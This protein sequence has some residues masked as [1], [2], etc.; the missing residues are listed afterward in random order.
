MELQKR[1]TG[2][3]TNPRHE[4]SV[5][6]DEAADVASIYRT[7]IVILAAIPAAAIVLG[8]LRFG[9][10]PAMSSGIA[11]YVMGVAQPIIVALAVEKLAPRFQ[12]T[13]TTVS[14]LKL[15]AYAA[16]PVW[17]AGAAYLLFFLVPLLLLAAL[18]SIYLFYL[19]LPILLGTP[20]DKAVPF[21]VVTAL[22]VIVTNI[23]LAWL[24]SGLLSHP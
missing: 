15:V 12:S 23:V 2:I 1:L 17:V 20:Q 22:A 21:M 9:M 24:L 13:A 8:R 19:G 3:L 14:A 7:Y 16:T 4:W 18:Y 11:N 5:I 6:A 10:G